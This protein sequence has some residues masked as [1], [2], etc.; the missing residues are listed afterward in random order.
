MK[1]LT[2]DLLAEVADALDLSS[3]SLVEKD[4][5]VVEVLA[6]L[7]HADLPQGISLVFA[8][9]TCLARAHRLVARMSEDVDLKITIAPLPSSKNAARKIL[10]AL[11]ETIRT[12]AADLGF[13]DPV[14]S[15]K[16]ENHYICAE[17]TYAD[18]TGE[19]VELL[20]H[21][22]VELTYAP[23]ALPTVERSVRSFVSEAT[24]SEPEIQQITCISVDE[25]A[26][27]KFVALTRRTAGY[28]EGRKTDAYDRFLIRH[29]YD[30]HCILP[31][32]DL[33]R[34][35]TLARQIMVSDAEQFKTWFPA[36]AADPEAG[37]EQALAYLMTNS[38]CRVS[39]DRFQAAMVYGQHFTYDTAMASV[40]SLYAAIKETED[41]VDEKNDV[42][43]NR[44][45][46][47]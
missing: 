41:H 4:Y 35:S 42:E 33:P 13:P 22:L 17:L 11:K 3:A 6:A 39:F 19:D 43:P 28:L 30:L 9:G 16:N 15:A 8:G 1:S 47:K 25:T 10:G 26:A 20:P 14:I 7:Q 46:S 44:R 40:Q 37:T 38:E 31:H 24:N 29:V 23:A 32:L 27:E 12:I 34:V 45:R 2:P 18:S 36:Y 21:L 5:R